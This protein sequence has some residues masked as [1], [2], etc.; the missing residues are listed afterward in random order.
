MRIW[1]NAWRV[2]ASV[3]AFLPPIA[4]SRSSL[5]NLASIDRLDATLPILSTAIED[6]PGIFP[7]ILAGVLERASGVSEWNDRAPSGSLSPIFNY[8]NSFTDSDGL[9]DQTILSAGKWSE[10]SKSLFIVLWAV[11]ICAYT[12][13]AYCIYWRE[14]YTGGAEWSDGI[15]DTYDEWVL[16]LVLSSF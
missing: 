8:P 4:Y 12:W 1:R 3:D 13:T 15:K 9:W 14:S 5:L 11:C 6:T 16:F 2:A 7:S 10:R